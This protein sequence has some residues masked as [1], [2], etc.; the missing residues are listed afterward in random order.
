[1]SKQSPRPA[2]TYRAARRNRVLR[3]ERG[4]WQC[5][6]EV[7][8][9]QYLVKPP[10]VKYDWARAQETPP[11][12]PAIECR[13]RKQPKSY[14]PNGKRECSRRARQANDALGSALGRRFSR[15]AETLGVAA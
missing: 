11:R 8:Y 15:E 5:A 10:V 9:Q 3:N 13:A 7:R 2:A 12:S 4:V 6:A 14:L 1:M